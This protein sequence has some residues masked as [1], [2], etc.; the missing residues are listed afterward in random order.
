MF[1]LQ[2]PAQDKR[3]RVT[4]Q[5]LKTTTLEH[6]F[7]DILILTNGEC[8]TFHPYVEVYRL[9]DGLPLFL[10]LLL[11]PPFDISPGCLRP[12]MNHRTLETR[13]GFIDH[14]LLHFDRR[15]LDHRLEQGAHGIERHIVKLSSTPFF[16]P[17]YHMRPHGRT[18][19][20]REHPLRQL[21][22]N[23]T[24]LVQHHPLRYPNDRIADCKKPSILLREQSTLT[25]QPKPSLIGHLPAM[26]KDT[27]IISLLG[28]KR[29]SLRVC[30]QHTHKE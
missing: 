19:L 4:V 28:I 10:R 26:L 7:I 5:R 23:S 12:T 29:N 1:F 6:Q 21:C 30:T 24:E 15:F 25:F 27:L 8:A 13:N 11:Q 9:Y 18:E 14:H 3:H 20:R 2:L 22:D 16:S 17:P